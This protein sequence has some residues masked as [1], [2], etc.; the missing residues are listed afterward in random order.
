MAVMKD[1][2]LSEIFSLKSVQPFV[3][4]RDAHPMEILSFFLGVS[5]K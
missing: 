5:E 2:C 4:G 1:L 3:A